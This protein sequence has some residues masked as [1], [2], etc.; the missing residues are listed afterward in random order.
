MF[1][2]ILAAA[3]LAA[4]LSITF[5]VVPASGQSAPQQA[6]VAP[7]VTPADAKPFVGNWSITGESPMGPFAMALLVAVEQGA[8]V[9]TISSDMQQPTRITNIT[10]TGDRLVLTYSFDYEGNS[11]PAILTLVPKGEALDAAFSFA[12]GAFEMG[13]VAKRAGAA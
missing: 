11:I 1:Q 6:P 2:S 13:G 10:R 4:T 9:A 12:D 3:G 8:V 7:T 5:A